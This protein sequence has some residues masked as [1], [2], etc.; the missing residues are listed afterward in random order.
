M[1]ALRRFYADPEWLNLTDGITTYFYDPSTV[2]VEADVA[3]QYPI[4]CRVKFTGAGDVILVVNHSEFQSPYTAI[5]VT[6]SFPPGTDAFYRYISPAISPGALVETGNT[7]GEVPIHSSTGPLLTG[8]YK[9]HGNLIGE[10]ALHTESGPLQAGAYLSAPMSFKYGSHAQQA[11]N[12][13]D[14]QPLWQSLTFP[15]TPNG[16]MKFM[17][18]VNLAW[19]VVSAPSNGRTTLYLYSGPAGTILDPIVARV[20]KGYTESGGNNLFITRF[21]VTPGA[22]DTIS[23]SFSCDTSSTILEETGYEIERVE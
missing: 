1:A 7:V 15:V 2:L 18:T 21:Q 8:A 13:T 22:S 3:S 9:N 23:I 12:S 4:G 5:V 16:A 20:S 17:V 10:L 19:N 14:Q 6:G 11:F